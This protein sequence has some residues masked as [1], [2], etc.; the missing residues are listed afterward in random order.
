MSEEVN[1]YVKQCKGY[2]LGNF[3]MCTPTI[4]TLFNH[5]K[6]KIPVYFENDYLF[7]LYKD[8]DCITPHRR[9]NPPKGKNLLFGSNL[10]N[11]KISD[12][13][14]IHKTIT[15]KK[16]IKSEV[17]PHTF[18]PMINDVNETGF[19]VVIRGCIKG[20]YWSKHK[21]IGDSIYKQI[22]ARLKELQEGRN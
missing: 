9:N 3:I 12:W 13:K 16:G 21:E 5:F 8:W 19:V 11:E 17:I 14:F 10:R 2:G 18:V 6:K 7:E 15:Q 4:I 20:S 1:F 22:K